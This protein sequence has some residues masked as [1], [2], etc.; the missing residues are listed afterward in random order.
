MSVVNSDW[1]AV[2]GYASAD[3]ACETRV[4][5]YVYVRAV[6]KTLVHAHILILVSASVLRYFKLAV[7]GHAQQRR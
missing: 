3:R 4:G 7:T 1:L 6:M 5:G 2:I